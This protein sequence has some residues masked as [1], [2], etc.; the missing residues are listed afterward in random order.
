MPLTPEQ[1][2]ALQSVPL[3]TMANK[4]RLARAM[5]E[6]QQSDIAKALG[7][8]KSQLSDIERGEYKDVPLENTRLLADYFGC[9]IEDLFPARETDRASA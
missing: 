7:F 8:L 3:G 1:L 6:Q 2:K 4:V 5:L 9:A